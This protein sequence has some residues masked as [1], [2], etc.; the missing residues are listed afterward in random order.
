[1]TRFRILIVAFFLFFTA[2]VAGAGEQPYVYLQNWA[3][4]D[5]HV[6]IDGQDF[7]IAAKGVPSCYYVSEGQHKIESYRV[8]NSWSHSRHCAW[9]SCFPKGEVWVQE[10]DF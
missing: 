5:L 6:Y 4:D 8:N 3:N 7:G 9:V 1:M 10:R 2:I